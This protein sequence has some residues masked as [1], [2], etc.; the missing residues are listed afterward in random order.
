MLTMVNAL[1]STHRPTI[2]ALQRP[3]LGELLRTSLMDVP[4][5]GSVCV[6][7]C[8]EQLLSFSW[9]GQDRSLILSFFSQRRQKKK[10]KKTGCFI[11][12][13]P[14]YFVTVNI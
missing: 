8:L 14:T 5:A 11:K 7:C 6:R 9:K 10:F 13:L 1:L 12:R 2:F 4:F 3:I